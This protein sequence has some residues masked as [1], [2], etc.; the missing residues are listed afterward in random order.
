MGLPSKKW[1]DLVA[2]VVAGATLNT[3]SVSEMGGGAW[4]REE[5]KEKDLQKRLKG[6]LNERGV[7]GYKIPKVVICVEALPRNAM[8]KVNKK[9]LVKKLVAERGWDAE[10]EYWREGK[11][12]GIDTMR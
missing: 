12:E 2:A 11:A 6:A 8:G 5:E 9:E 3:G 10:R 1:G 7:A 4:R